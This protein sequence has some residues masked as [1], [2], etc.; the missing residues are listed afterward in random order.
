MNL[1]GFFLNPVYAVINTISSLGEKLMESIQSIRK[2]MDWMRFS[3]FSLIK[4]ILGIFVN[5]ISRFQLLIINIK[6]LIMRMIAVGIVLLYQIK[7]GIATMESAHDGP[8]GHLLRFLG[9]FPN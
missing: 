1:M 8:P 2:M 6:S 3:V 5:I 9:N 7:S 4:D